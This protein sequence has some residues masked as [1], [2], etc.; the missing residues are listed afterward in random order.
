MLVTADYGLRA[1][2][3]ASV[4]KRCRLSP[5]L[6]FPSALTLFSFQL[7]VCH[8]DEASSLWPDLL[9]PPTDRIDDDDED[10]LPMP[11]AANVQLRAGVCVRPQELMRCFA[12]REASDHV[13]ARNQLKLF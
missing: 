2:S 9:Q 6:V 8:Y 11:S 7:H 13:L 3:D 5:T 1:K 4:R 10:L 12:C